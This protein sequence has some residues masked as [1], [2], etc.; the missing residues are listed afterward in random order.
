MTIEQRLA[1]LEVRIAKLEKEAVAATTAE[2]EKHLQGLPNST[3]TIIFK[4][5]EKTKQDERPVGVD[6]ESYL[7]KEILWQSR[8]IIE[9]EHSIVEILN[10]V[11]HLKYLLTKS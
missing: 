2:T 8:K 11:K 4:E 3:K 9:L 1:D 7:A 10:T 6:P 5:I